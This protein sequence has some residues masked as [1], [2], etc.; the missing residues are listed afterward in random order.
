MLVNAF[1]DKMSECPPWSL[2]DLERL[3]AR[4]DPGRLLEVVAEARIRTLAWIAADWMVRERGSR[5]W[6]AVRDRIGAPPPRRLYALA[7]ERSAGGREPSVASR[8]LTRVVSDSA[9]RRCW[10]L[11]AAGAGTVVSWVGS[12]PGRQGR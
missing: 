1:K 6:G 8:V 3:G 7:W 9:W 5:R 12:R 2:D 4:V 11:A 10:A